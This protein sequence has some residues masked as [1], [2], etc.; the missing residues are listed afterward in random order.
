M[1]VS[2][3][4]SE[5]WRASLVHETDLDDSGM[6]TPLLSNSGFTSDTTG[7]AGKTG[8]FKIHSTYLIRTNYSQLGTKRPTEQIVF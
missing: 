1:M 5:E 8:S 3:S 2:G 7:K 6:M 4:S